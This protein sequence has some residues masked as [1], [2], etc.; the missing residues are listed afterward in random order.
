MLIN[1]VCTHKMIRLIKRKWE[2]SFGYTCYF[3]IKCIIFIY[4]IFWLFTLVFCIT[5]IFESLFYCICLLKF[6]LKL[7]R[8]AYFVH[9][10]MYFCPSKVCFHF[11]WIHHTHTL[12]S[13]YRPLFRHSQNY[14]LDLISNFYLLLNQLR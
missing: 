7:T 10:F 6:P 13:T 3:L 2:G 5:N 12:Y 9:L 8:H 1:P 14:F 4:N 11:H